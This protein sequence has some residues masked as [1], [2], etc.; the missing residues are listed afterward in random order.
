VLAVNAEGY[1]GRQ[2]RTLFIVVAFVMSFCKN[3][4][5]SKTALVL[6]TRLSVDRTSVAITTHQTTL[7]SW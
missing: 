3:S 7:A 2:V 6:F 1:S 4:E 5:L